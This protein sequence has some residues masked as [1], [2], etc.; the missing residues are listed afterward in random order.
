MLPKYAAL[1]CSGC[2]VA[3]LAGNSGGPLFDSS[4]RVVGMNTATYTRSGTVRKDMLY[5]AHAASK[6]R[7]LIPLPLVLDFQPCRPGL[8]LIPCRAV[9]VVSTSPCPLT[10]LETLCP[11]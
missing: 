10:W 9:A 1:R 6:I 5:Q 2:C 4:G 3:L 8:R 7:Y 11:S